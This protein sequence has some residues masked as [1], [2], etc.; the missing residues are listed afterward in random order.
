VV[1]TGSL[2]GMLFAAEGAQVEA[3]LNGI[4]TVRLRF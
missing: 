3:T 4:G 1:T 2:T